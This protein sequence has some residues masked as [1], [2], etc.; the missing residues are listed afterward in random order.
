MALLGQRYGT[1]MQQMVAVYVLAPPLG[2][3]HEQF[4]RDKDV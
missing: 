4:Q 2:L 1:V 3:P